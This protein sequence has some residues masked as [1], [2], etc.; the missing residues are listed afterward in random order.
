MKKK[1]L[2]ILLATAVIAGVGTAGARA[3]AAYMN[4][5]TGKTVINKEVKHGLTITTSTENDDKDVMLPGQTYTTTAFVKNTAN[6]TQRLSLENID[7]TLSKYAGTD[8][9][10]TH[11]LSQYF[12]YEYETGIQKELFTVTY[13]I[14]G[15]DF[16]SFEELKNA[17]DG[18]V[19]AFTNN[20]SKLITVKI[21]YNDIDFVVSENG[22]DVGGHPIQ[23]VNRTDYRFNVKVDVLGY[24]VGSN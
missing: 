17:F 4:R 22:N 15:E 18:N 13:S 11:P 21:Q 19:P 16:V 7:V 3:Y 10:E 6:Y 12:V 24:S 5:A 9:E 14:N 23:G 2:S 8:K 20:Q 1:L